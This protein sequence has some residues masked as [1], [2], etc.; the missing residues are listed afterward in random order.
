MRHYFRYALAISRITKRLQARYE[1]KPLARRLVG[2]AGNHTEDDGFIVAWDGLDVKPSMLASVVTDSDQLIRLFYLSAQFGQLPKPELID[3]IRRS[4]S[5]LHFQLTELG[6]DR[7][8]EILRCGSMLGS[9]LRSMDEAGLLELIIPDFANV[10]CLLQFNQYH[11]YTVDEHT[12]RAV[13]ELT[14][15][16]DDE[17]AS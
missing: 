16:K 15:L 7:F 10:H 9:I 12:F 4:I 11:A 3:Q 13:E 2:L 17:G 14:K 1:K 5:S 6:I 8:C